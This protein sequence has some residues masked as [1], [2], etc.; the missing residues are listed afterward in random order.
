MFLVSLS[1]GFAHVLYGNGLSPP[2]IL[3]AASMNAKVRVSLLEQRGS[4]D[5]AF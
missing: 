3:L 4:G 5:L 2:G 1:R